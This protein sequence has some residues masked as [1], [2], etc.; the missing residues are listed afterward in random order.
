[1]ISESLSRI[2]QC[3]S[4]NDFLRVH[5]HFQTGKFPN[6]TTGRDKTL[7]FNKLSVFEVLSL[8][9]IFVT[10]HVVRLKLFRLKAEGIKKVRL[11]HFCGERADFHTKHGFKMSRISVF[12]NSLQPSVYPPE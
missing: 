10:T 2:A 6:K 9:R 4:Q 12:P 3:H 5:Q 8:A 1:V 11:T 7:S